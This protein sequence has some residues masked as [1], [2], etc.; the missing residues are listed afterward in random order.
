V[1]ICEKQKAISKKNLKRNYYQATKSNL[2]IEEKM[3]LR[4][5]KLIA[6]FEKE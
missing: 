1:T 6:P 2:V 4:R 3:A 5:F